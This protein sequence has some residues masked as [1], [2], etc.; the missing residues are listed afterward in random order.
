VHC[1]KGFQDLLCPCDLEE[2]PDEDITRGLIEASLPKEPRLGFP[3]WMGLRK[4]DD[5]YAQLL[6]K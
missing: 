1:F 3:D 4:E 5:V 2:T 6:K